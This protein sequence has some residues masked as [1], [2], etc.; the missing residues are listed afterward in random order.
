MLLNLSADY[1]L[2]VCKQVA[3]LEAEAARTAK[4]LLQLVQANA[5]SEACATDLQARL[6]DKANALHSA[7]A[8]IAELAQERNDEAARAAAS[9]Q[10]LVGVKVCTCSK[11]IHGQKACACDT[12][13]ANTLT[14]MPA[15][16][17]RSWTWCAAM[18]ALRPARTRTW[19]SKW[20]S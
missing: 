13:W 10:E 8:R 6:A 15:T 19:P 14:V 17:R 11:C 4:Q 5:A 3:E 18:P 2:G 7:Q 1:L 20:R 12:S 9:S 16:R